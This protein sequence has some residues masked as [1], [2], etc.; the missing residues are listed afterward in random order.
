MKSS[1]ARPCTIGEAAAQFGLATSVLRHWDGVGVLRPAFRSGGQRRY[2]VDDVYRIGVIL[3]C[4]EAG[5][6]LD[7]IARLLST[8]RARERRAL[9]RN[10]EAELDTRIA[11]A[12]AARAMIREVRW[13][14]A[15]DPLACPRFRATIDANRSGTPPPRR[16]SR[17]H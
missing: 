9:L 16:S 15:P 12:T 8:R 1:A 4:Q 2:S 7:E 10:K 17:R 14:S 3:F 6:S 5:L 13:C 11:S